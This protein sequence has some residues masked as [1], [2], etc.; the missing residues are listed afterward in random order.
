MD[1]GGVVQ[2]TDVPEPRLEEG[3]ITSKKGEPGK[4]IPIGGLVDTP[5]SDPPPAE[6]AAGPTK[7][8]VKEEEIAFEEGEPSKESR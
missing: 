2:A 3:A 1:E 7:L 6:P 5:P 8:I 4:E